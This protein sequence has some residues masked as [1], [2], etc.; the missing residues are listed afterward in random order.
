MLGTQLS[1]GEYLQRCA[2]EL[3]SLDTAALERLSDA[4][5]RAY[6][7]GRFVF[8]CGNGGS[9]SNASHFC[10]LHRLSGLKHWTMFEQHFCFSHCAARPAQG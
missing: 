9:G 6:E 7:Q 10:L 2:R 4:I 8:I 3:D 5:F 1:Q